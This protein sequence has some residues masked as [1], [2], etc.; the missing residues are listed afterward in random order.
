VIPLKINTV[1]NNRYKITDQ[2]AITS[3]KIVYLVKDL[4]INCSMVLKQYS[5]QPQHIAKVLQ[6]SFY[7]IPK[8]TDIYHA[9]DF[10]VIEN[11]ISGESLDRIQNI[12]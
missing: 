4:K 7:N 3:N 6:W 11:Y 10:F 1:V 8:L 9:K 5:M 12:N 2:L